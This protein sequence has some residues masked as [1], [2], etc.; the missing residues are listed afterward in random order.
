MNCRCCSSNR[1][2]R[3]FSAVWHRSASRPIIRSF[4]SLD[5]GNSSDPVQ[6]IDPNA[7]STGKDYEAT[8]KKVRDAALTTMASLL[9]LGSAGYIYHKYYKR[10]VLLKIE[11]AF[12]PGDPMLELYKRRAE[13]GVAGDEDAEDHWIR[14]PEQGL[15]DQI[16]RGD[17]VGHYFVL[18][19]ERGLGKK[20]M[21]L[22]AMRAIDGDRVSM[23]DAHRDAEIF[24]LRLGKALDYEFSEDFAGSLFFCARST[25]FDAAA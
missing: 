10:L 8:S 15:I 11:N 20:T 9:V 18:L 5:G 21:L 14:R 19:G 25:G 7:Q 4:A 12:R 23:V 22:D 1:R 3:I 2:L 16:I 24:R 17:R 13:G 6:S